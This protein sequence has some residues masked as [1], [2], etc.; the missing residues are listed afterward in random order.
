[1][2]YVAACADSGADCDAVIRADTMEELQKKTAPWN[3]RG[4]Y[5]RQ[6][7]SERPECDAHPILGLGV[8][9]ARLHGCPILLPLLTC[10]TPHPV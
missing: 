9:D 6:P 1:M 2:A 7:L 8:L 4:I 5:K 3:R 10:S